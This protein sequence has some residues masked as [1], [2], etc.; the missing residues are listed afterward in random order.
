VVVGLLGP[1]DELEPLLDPHA[2]IAPATAATHASVRILVFILR[3][4]H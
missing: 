4:P 2:M 3:I 1:A